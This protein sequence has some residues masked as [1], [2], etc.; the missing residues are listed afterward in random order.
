MPISSGANG[1]NLVEAR[2][3]ILVEPILNPAAEVQAIGRIHRIGQTNATI[4]H[5]FLIHD[6][7]EERMY[8]FLH[9]K[10]LENS[11]EDQSL[12]IEDL[13]QLFIQNE[14]EENS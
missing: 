9:P 4:V 13:Y 12:T 3:V 6:T 14:N 7:I 2:H 11:T 8:N 1:L 5:R 10:Y